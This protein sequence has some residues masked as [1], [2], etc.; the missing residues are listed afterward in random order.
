MATKDEEGIFTV[1][2]LFPQGAHIAPSPGSCAPSPLMCAAKRGHHGAIRF[3]FQRGSPINLQERHKTTCLHVAVYSADVKTLN[4][5]L[6]VEL[7]ILL[8]K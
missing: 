7:M 2:D 5:I 8:N 3:L 4:I 1:Y 6:Q